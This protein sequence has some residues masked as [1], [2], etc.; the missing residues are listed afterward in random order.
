MRRGVAAYL[1]AL[2]LVTALFLLFPGIDL[3]AAGLFY[4]P[5]GSFF[6][7]QS[8]WVRA[9]YRG[10]PYLT[11]AIVLGVPVLYLI[12]RLRRRPLFGID[13]RAAAFLLLSLALGPGLLVNS[14]LKD[15]WGRARPA[16][17][18]QF[19]GHA[20]FSPAP[21]PAEQ[22]PRNCSFPAGHPAIGF[23]LVS[24][25]ML[26][27]DP[28]RRRLAASAAIAFGAAIGVARMAA[29][30]HFLSDVVFSGF[31]VCGMSWLLHRA[32]VADQRFLRGFEALAPPRRL[33]LPAL[34]LLA[35]VLLFM[36]FLDRPIARFFHDSATPS[37]LAVFDFITQ[38]GLGGG[39]LV[40]TAALFILCRAAAAVARSAGRAALLLH[41]AHRALYLFLAV[42]GSGLVADIAKVIFGR[43]RPKLL[44]ADGIYA[45]NWGATQADY[46]SFPSGHAT[47]IAAVAVA[48]YLLW[49]RGW[50][51]YLVAALLVAASRIIIAE[52]Y[53]SDVLVG[54]ALGA[55]FAWALWQGFAR[56]GVAL[57]DVA[58]QPAVE[59]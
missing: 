47:T 12:G 43:A 14:V 11:D 54:A 22:C 39:Y 38:F 28:R 20:R 6:L 56:A 2:A 33:V 29:G 27:P 18:A 13:G 25:A 10:V 52:H 48:L 32:L 45:F 1:A 35:V 26:V 7:S 49:P 41:Y 17:V 40:V 44:F 16:Q 59:R 9:I 15:H 3:R 19:G 37:L 36:A 8:L 53:A 34:L 21:L 58:P 50:P 23:Y 51:L 5:E 46:W 55:G 24:F 30:G 31:I 57:G 42:A 4:R